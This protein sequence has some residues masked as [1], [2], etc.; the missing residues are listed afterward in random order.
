MNLSNI[1]NDELLSNDSNEQIKSFRWKGVG[2]GIALWLIDNTDLTFEQIANFCC[3]HRLEVQALADDETG[4]KI[5]P[6]DPILMQLLDHETIEACVADKTKQLSLP[7]YNALSMK[8]A[9][10]KSKSRYVTITKKKNKP[11]AISWILKNHPYISDKQIISLVGT[12][13]NTIQSIR[14]KTY[15]GTKDLKSRSPV[16]LGLCT[17]EQLSNTIMYAK[18]FHDRQQIE[19]EEKRNSEENQNI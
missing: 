10:Q 7:P 16:V 11:D 13:K 1:I 5:T 14:D 18:M 9:F 15:K 8:L 6:H 3:I 4:E 19:N 2:K 17:N 12:T